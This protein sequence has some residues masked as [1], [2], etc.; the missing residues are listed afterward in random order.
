MAAVER[1]PKA[2]LCTGT[3]PVSIAGTDKSRW[4]NQP[5]AIPVLVGSRSYLEWDD[6][7]GC[8]L[9]FPPSRACGKDARSSP[10][11]HFDHAPT[12]VGDLA[13][14]RE[15]LG[16]NVMAAE[17]RHAAEHSIVVADNLVIVFVR[18]RIPRIELETRHLVQPDGTDEVLAHA[19]RA[20]ARDTA[21]ALDAAVQLIDLLGQFGIHA[22]FCPAQVHFSLFHMDPG[23]QTLAHPAHPLTRVHRQI[24]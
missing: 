16:T 3:M 4:E 14:E 18:A 24:A 12:Q 11:T 2:E 20:A 23:A 5:R 19:R 9:R 1:E 13:G 21:A 7:A 6:D 8:R 10:P 22:F 15:I 17:Q